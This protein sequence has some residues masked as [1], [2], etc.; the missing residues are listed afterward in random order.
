[1]VHTGLHDANVISININFYQV[2]KSTEFHKEID[3]TLGSLALPTQ[4]SH[5]AVVYP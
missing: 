4:V 3:S 5:D 1:M 2:K